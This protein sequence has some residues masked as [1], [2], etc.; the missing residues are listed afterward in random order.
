M[1]RTD[2]TRRTARASTLLAGAVFLLAP[3]PASGSAEPSGA[4]LYRQACAHCHG[5]DGRGVAQERL[6]LEVPVPDFTDC[7]FATREPDADWV[8]VAH[9]GGPVRGFS[10]QMPAFGDALGV[11]ELE[12]VMEH[13]RTFCPD[14]AWPRGELNLPRALVTEKAYPED[15]AVFTVGAT[16]GG[17]GE[18]ST[19]LVYETRFGARNQVELSVPLAWRETA[20]EEPGAGGRDGWT[21]GP[22]DV[23]V[24]VK[25]AVYHS[26]ERG[27]VFSIAAEVLLPTGD[28]DRGFGAGTP[29]V[30]P[31]VAYGRILPADGFL[32]LQAGA[33]LPVD[34]DRAT[35]EAFWRLAVGKT[36]TEGRWG[37]AWSPMVEVLGSREL[38][39][40]E[41]A[42]WDL[43]PQVQVTLNQRQHVM[44]DVGIRLPVAETRGRDP[45]VLVYLLWD[46]FDGGFLE[47][48]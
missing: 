36:F 12:R 11:A 22:G 25:R 45:E 7:S 41:E 35:E 28:E 5:A 2:R 13:V 4:E 3:L 37:R 40:G 43:L 31:F 48:W 42:R 1:D 34:T 44:L 21:S 6:R 10:R 47:G 38:T 14:P 18:V 30:E 8:A 27:D 17:A 33:E 26:L 16:T 19:E 20:P 29:V 32:H 9:E 23:A 15:E 46:W 39:G 24:G